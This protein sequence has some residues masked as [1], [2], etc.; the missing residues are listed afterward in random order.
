[1]YREQAI[2]KMKEY[3]NEKR[4]IEHTLKVLGRAEQICEGEGIENPFVREVATLGSIFHDI[5]IPEALRKHNS[6]DAPFQEQEGPAV[7]RKLM[8]E[9][10]VRPD[11]LERV[12]FIVGHHHTAGQVDGVDFQVIWEADF[13][14][15]IDE[16]NIVL[17]ADKVESAVAENLKT[18]TAL[19]LIREVL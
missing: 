11:I 18:P 14:V 10:G 16:K 12:C 9:V 1:M 2:E 8:A 5:G 7:A 15:N 19:S 4:F 13:I 17:Q 3:F 6:M